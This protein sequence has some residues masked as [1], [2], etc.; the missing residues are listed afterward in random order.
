MAAST[1]L[2]H[3]PSV[4]LQRLGKRLD[5]GKQTLLQVAQEKAGRRLHALRFAAQALLPSLLV[6]AEQRG[7]L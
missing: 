5:G 4:D 1:L 7:E 6:L 3:G 2:L